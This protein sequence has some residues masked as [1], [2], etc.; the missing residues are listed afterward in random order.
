MSEQTYTLL[1]NSINT[2]PN[3]TN[4]TASTNNANTSYTN[5]TTPT[6]PTILAATS[7][8]LYTTQP[9]D[10]TAPTT[11]ASA[12]T[13]VNQSINTLQPI[14]SQQGIN[15]AVSTTEELYQQF[16][17]LEKYDDTIA[18]QTLPRNLRNYHCIHTCCDCK[19]TNTGTQSTQKKLYAQ[20]IQPNNTTT[21][22]VNTS[23]VTDN[24]QSSLSNDATTSSTIQSAATAA[25]NNDT[26]A[27]ASKKPRRAYSKSD[28]V[29]SALADDEL[30]ARETYMSHIHS[31]EQHKKCDFQCHYWRKC[32]LLS[33]LIYAWTKRRPIQNTWKMA[34]F[35]KRTKIF[36]QVCDAVYPGLLPY[37]L[38]QFNNEKR[39]T[40]YVV[41]PLIDTLPKWPFTSRG[42]CV[43]PD[44]QHIDYSN[45]PYLHDTFDVIHQSMLPWNDSYQHTWPLV[46][47]YWLA[48]PQQ[49]KYGCQTYDSYI[50][51]R[52]N[53]FT[54][55]SGNSNTTTRL[56]LNQQLNNSNDNNSDSTNHN[57]SS[58]N[59]LPALP[60]ITIKRDNPTS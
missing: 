16:I 21:D 52:N 48:D 30:S 9:H 22:N 37:T 1:P 53:T 57:N 33:R 46:H 40:P 24:Q 19:W 39:R 38:Y 55:S 50:Y 4:P 35:T 11:S 8:N 60:N 13:T 17:D 10:T 26:N 14:Y 32:M 27:R 44:G 15:I 23:N 31:Y 58:N 49:R 12:N 41:K 45:S 7:S 18:T 56:F 28:S 59:T 25:S 2:N 6:L 36:D 43:L 34:L 51:E 42:I 47:D 5:D 3:I 29:A 54:T 20:N